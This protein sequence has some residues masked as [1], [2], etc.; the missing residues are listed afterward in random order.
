MAFIDFGPETGGENGT[1]GH[2]A[3]SRALL[4]PKPFAAGEQSMAHNIADD[5][6]LMDLLQEDEDYRSMEAIEYGDPTSRKEG[7]TALGIISMRKIGLPA[8]MGKFVDLDRDTVIRRAI[9][10]ELTRRE[11]RGEHAGYARQDL[12]AWDTSMGRIE[13]LIRSRLTP[14]EDKHLSSELAIW[15]QEMRHKADYVIR[16]ANK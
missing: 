8:C 12:P 16:A 7:V 3:R 6:Q 1:S 4:E 15:A 13:P 14:E 2:S 10:T 11:I 9:K 5:R